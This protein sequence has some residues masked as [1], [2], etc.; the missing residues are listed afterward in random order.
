MFY[1][2]ALSIYSCTRLE[3]LRN[4]TAYQVACCERR[5]ATHARPAVDILTSSFYAKSIALLLS[6]HPSEHP[7]VFHATARPRTRRSGGSFLHRARPLSLIGLFTRSRT[8]GRGRARRPQ[9]QVGWSSGEGKSASCS[10]PKFASK[11][12][13]RS[14]RAR[15][16]VVYQME[17]RG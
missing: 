17:E 1:N 5:L 11:S 7:P 8:R 10:A 14:S 16:R 4:F 2:T 12:A 15:R 13:E 3:P 9:R 6:S